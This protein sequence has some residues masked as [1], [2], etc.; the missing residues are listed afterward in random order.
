MNYNLAVW[1]DKS[2]K[3]LLMKKGE[4]IRERWREGKR[5]AGREG[6][7]ERNTYSSQ[8]YELLLQT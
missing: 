1:K 6:R 7:R 8:R 4:G 2:D 3:F 5:V